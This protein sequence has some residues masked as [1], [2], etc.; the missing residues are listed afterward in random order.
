MSARIAQRELR[1]RSGDV[2]RRAEAGELITITVNG[3]P[4]AQLGPIPRRQ[5][6]KK[7][8]YLAIFRTGIRDPSF[9]KNVRDMGG[10]LD[11]LDDRWGL[12]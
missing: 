11:E 4:V 3:R 9:L 6:L 8:E 10:A 5:F 1:N 2:L 12:E 7:A